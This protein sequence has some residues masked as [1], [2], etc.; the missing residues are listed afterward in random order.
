MS[1]SKR[2]AVAA[3]AVRNRSSRERFRRR[4]AA[5]RRGRCEG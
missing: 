4:V 2:A 5:G 1:D 3:V